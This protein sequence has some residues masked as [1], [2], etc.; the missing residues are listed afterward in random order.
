M[1]SGEDVKNVE[2]NFRFMPVERSAGIIFFRNTPRGRVYLVIRSSNHIPERGEFWDF[3]KG[4]LEKGETGIQAAEREAVEEVDIK[5]YELQPDFKETVKYFTRRS[6]RMKFV[7]MFL[8]EAKGAKVKLS[9]EHDAYEWLSYEKAYKRISLKP[10]KEALKKAN[11]HLQ[12][13]SS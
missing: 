5:K 9:W 10:M 1:A 6:G 8:A 3:P 7:A 4:R 12:T 13:K 2:I 11:D